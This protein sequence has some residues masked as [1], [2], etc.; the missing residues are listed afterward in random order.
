MLAILE[1]SNCKLP[2][3]VTLH[4]HVLRLNST[5]GE[6]ARKD[7]IEPRAEATPITSASGS[8]QL[9]PGRPKSPK[10]KPRVVLVGQK[11]SQ[12][13]K[14]DTRFRTEEATWLAEAWIRQ[15]VKGP[16]QNDEGIR[17][18]ISDF[19]SNEHGMQRT[20]DALRNKWS[21]LAHE[22]Q[23]YLSVK[24]QVRKHP[25]TGQAEKGLKMLTMDMYCSRSKRKDADG[26]ERMVVTENS[27][28]CSLST[29]KEQGVVSRLASPPDGWI[30]S[31]TYHTTLFLKCRD[32]DETNLYQVN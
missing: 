11:K 10:N 22:A 29:E 18:E 14:E 24:G 3:G 30:A 17:E 25:S 21:V 8:V 27:L 6:T 9:N 4:G 1:K 5:S 7:V 2:G 31:G 28:F 26:A 19:L 15:S 16:N 12:A 23:V 32:F 13:G 20:A